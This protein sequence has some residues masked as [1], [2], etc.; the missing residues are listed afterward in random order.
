MDGV[1]NYNNCCAI[2]V[3]NLDLYTH[4]LMLTNILVYNT[5]V[6]MSRQ[7][8]QLTNKTDRD[9]YKSIENTLFYS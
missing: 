8:Y 9:V 3:H 7:P 5:I 6:A 1:L 4:V 2:Q